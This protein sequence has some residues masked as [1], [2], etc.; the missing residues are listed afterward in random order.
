MKIIS[1]N[2]RGL[3]DPSKRHAIYTILLPYKADIVFLRES[4]LPH[5]T[6]SIVKQ[7]VGPNLSGWSHVAEDGSKGGIITAWNESVWSLC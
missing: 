2:T 1:W 7:M 4:K 6:Q 3:G 5:L